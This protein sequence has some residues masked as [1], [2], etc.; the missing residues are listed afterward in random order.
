MCLGL[1]PEKGEFQMESYAWQAMRKLLIGGK[2][3]LLDRK[4]YNQVLGLWGRLLEI[5]KGSH[6]QLGNNY[7]G[8]IPAWGQARVA[9]R[10]EMFRSME[11]RANWNPVH[12]SKKNSLVYCLLSGL[13][14]VNSCIPS[15]VG[16][17]LLYLLI[18]LSQP[19]SNNYLIIIIILV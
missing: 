15:W 16:G 18:L 2:Y 9:S 1:K 3:C 13:H 8:I 7:Y 14:L 4:K 10:R 17:I 6:H 11:N 5:G 12:L 19:V